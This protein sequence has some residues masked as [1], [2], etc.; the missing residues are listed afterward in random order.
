[1]LL[2]G[3]DEHGDAQRFGNTSQKNN[4]MLMQLVACFDTSLANLKKTGIKSET[5][6]SVQRCRVKIIII[7]REKSTK[8][9]TILINVD[10]RLHFIPAERS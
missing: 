1:M 3:N 5:K 2:G 9:I 8:R 4:A 7:A 6:R 10:E